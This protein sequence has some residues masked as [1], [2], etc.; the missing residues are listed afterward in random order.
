MTQRENSMRQA[1]LLLAGQAENELADGYHDR[2]VLLALAALETILILPRQSTP[3][4]RQ[5]LITVP[6]RSI[7]NTNPR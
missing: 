1:A 3:W 5:F 4:D 6:C 2:A 7:P